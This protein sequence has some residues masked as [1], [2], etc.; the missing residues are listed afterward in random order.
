M[1]NTA[2]AVWRWAPRLAGIAMALFLAVFALDAFD[3]RP[4]FAAL[5]G[6]IIHLLPACLVLVAVVV[7]W[8][9]PIAGAV[10]FSGLAVMYAVSVKWRLGWIALIGAPLLI[11]G[12]LFAVSARH[13]VAR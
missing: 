4:F 9:F 8:R 6:F 7:A 2:A 3:G 12:A 1:T 5:P 10:A 13:R 11:I